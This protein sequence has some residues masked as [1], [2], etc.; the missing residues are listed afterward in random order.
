MKL[1]KTKIKGIKIIKSK[2]F[3]KGPMSKVTG[4]SGR[5]N[6]TMDKKFEGYSNLQGKNDKE[7]KRIQ[8]GAGQQEARGLEDE[9]ILTL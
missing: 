7:Q 2:I 6:R 5:K 8:K 4:A 3:K 1:L 9:M